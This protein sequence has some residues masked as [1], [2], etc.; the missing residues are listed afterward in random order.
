M[1]GFV[2][3]YAAI[4]RGRHTAERAYRRRLRRKDDTRC[5][6]I[7]YPSQTSSPLE[8]KIVVHFGAV[9]IV[10]GPCSIIKSR[11]T[12]PHELNIHAVVPEGTLCL[13]GT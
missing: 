13:A 6:A 1:K 10:S 2:N 9:Y 5:A 7:E 3:I 4:A 8:F 12:E 11:V